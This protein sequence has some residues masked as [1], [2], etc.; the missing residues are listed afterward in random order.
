MLTWTWK[1]HFFS[2]CDFHFSLTIFRTCFWPRGHVP[3]GCWVNKNWRSWKAD[4]FRHNNFENQ[5]KI[6]VV[7]ALTIKVS[8]TA[9]QNHH[10]TSPFRSSPHLR[11]SLG[12]SENFSENGDLV[13][14]CCKSDG[15]WTESLR[16]QRNLSVFKQWDLHFDWNRI[17]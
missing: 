14:L 3:R 11:W 16:D 2:F 5:N 13:S 9:Y 17:K 8:W 10:N 12:I 1:G 15:I 7:M 4:M 6:E